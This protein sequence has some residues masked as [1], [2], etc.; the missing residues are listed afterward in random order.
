MEGK[1]LEYNI[2]SVLM[3]SVA[4]RAHK[5]EVQ[6]MNTANTPLTHKLLKTQWA[7]MRELRRGSFS[8]VYIIHFPLVFTTQDYSKETSCQRKVTGK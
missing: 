4:L 8:N 5:L 7:I 1:S 6:V 2:N 3:I